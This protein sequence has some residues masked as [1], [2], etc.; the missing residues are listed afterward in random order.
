MAGSAVLI[1]A[2]GL[3]LVYAG[4]KDVPLIAGLR[5]IMQGKAPQGSE[6]RP[7]AP[8]RP[9]E[10]GVDTVSSASGIGGRQGGCDGPL[11][12]CGNAA[13]GYA[14]MKPL[15][16]HIN[17]GGY[18]PKGSVPGSRHPMG[19]AVDW[20][21]TSNAEAQRIIAAFKKTRGARVWIWNRQI[22]SAVTGWKISGYD[23]PSPHTDHVHVDWN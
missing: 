5:Q 9:A 2:A 14:Q 7:Y 1:G 8:T 22:A 4:V 23:G 16:P 3:Y 20:P 6:K 15:F 19:L 13:I 21:T 11:G 12:L 17:A 18:R 10:F